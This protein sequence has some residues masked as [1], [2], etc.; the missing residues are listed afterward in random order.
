M[1]AIDTRKEY[2]QWSS[3]VQE[4]TF[5]TRYWINLGSCNKLCIS[6]LNKHAVIEISVNKKLK[7]FEWHFLKIKMLHNAKIFEKQASE[8]EKYNT[9]EITVPILSEH[10]VYAIIFNKN[11]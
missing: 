3:I 4:Y 5:R 9:M 2:I 6:I 1:F 11:K 10:V 8:K 7:C